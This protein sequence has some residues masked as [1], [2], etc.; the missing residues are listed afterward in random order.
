MK[1]ILMVVGA[2]TVTALAVGVLAFALLAV[3]GRRLDASSREYATQLLDTTLKHWEPSAVKVESSDELIAAV[4]DH[5]LAQLLGTFSERLGPIRS[6]GAPQGEARLSIMPFRRVV[7]ADYVTPVTFEKAD[8]NIA[9]RL[10]LRDG[11]WKLLVLNVFSDA[12]L[13]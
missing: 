3:E 2:V 8:G 5:K 12:L 11:R 6:H 13:R 7:T 1:R 4:P 10:I 9:L